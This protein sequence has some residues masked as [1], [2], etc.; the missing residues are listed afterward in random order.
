MR[1]AASASETNGIAFAGLTASGLKS[2]TRISLGLK[3]G[4]PQRRR[5]SSL[6]RSLAFTGTFNDMEQPGTAGTRK[7]VVD[8]VAARRNLVSRLVRRAFRE[9]RFLDQSE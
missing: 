5:S 2:S 8:K 3:G 1:S 6:P 9:A 4:L 7:Q